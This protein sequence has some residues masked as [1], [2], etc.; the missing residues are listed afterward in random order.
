[1]ADLEVK[2]LGYP[3]WIST[4]A[5]VILV[6]A[7]V[8]GVIENVT[9]LY[10]FRRQKQLRSPTN[11]LIVALMFSDL[12]IAIG[13]CPITAYSGFMGYWALGENMC[14]FEGWLV[15]CFGL[16]SLYLLMI[17][18]VDRYIM[19]ANPLKAAF[20]TNRVSVVAIGLCFAA[21]MFWSVLPLLGWSAYGHEPC[22]FA[23]G[24][25]WTE[26]SAANKSYIICM[27]IFCFFVP[28]I[29]IL[30]CY[31]HVYMTVSIGINP[32][33]YNYELSMGC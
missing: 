4:T 9:V 11:N 24:L 12:C 19:I 1:M 7:S 10:M 5:G 25:D 15:Y 21:G 26:P 2:T 17:V 28:L 8:I 6:I 16:T 22:G 18:S 32:L 30:Y 31:Y 33:Y 20:I 13:S 3:R 23:C 29:V 27:F 14:I